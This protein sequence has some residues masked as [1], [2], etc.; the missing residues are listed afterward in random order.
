[1]KNLNWYPGHMKKTERLIDESLSMV[2]VVCEVL[3][4]RIPVSSRNL[5]ISEKLQKRNKNR[6]ILLNKSDLADEEEN[7]RWKERLSGE[8]G[9]EDVLIVNSLTGQGFAPLL[10]RLNQRSAKGRP[11]RV[12]VVGIP[13]VGKSSVINRLAKRRGAQV[14][15]KPGVTKGKQWIGA[16]GGVQILDT[17]GI[18][19]P[20]FDD[21]TGTHL[22][23]CAAIKEEIFDVEDLGYEFIGMLAKEYPSLLHERYGVEDL[24]M[25]TLEIMDEIARKRGFLLKGGKL[26]YGRTARTV[27]DEF[28]TGKLGRLTLEKVK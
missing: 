9:V 3:D 10:A 26:D 20:K 12:M 25:P 5:M 14:G 28:R 2:D 23:I 11:M 4:A 21:V 27:L 19:W 7:L 17:P 8:E 1:M 18:L 24:D 15:N 6:I 13:N 16:T 22:A